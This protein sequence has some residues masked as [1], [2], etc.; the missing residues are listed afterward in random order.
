MTLNAKISITFAKDQK[1]TANVLFLVAVL[2]LLL[3]GIYGWFYWG[4]LKPG[5][6]QGWVFVFSAPIYLTL[7]LVVRWIKHY[8]LLIGFG[9]Y[10]YLAFTVHPVPYALSG[11]W[12]DGLS[13]KLPVLTFLLWGWLAGV[14]QR[15]SKRQWETVLIAILIVL[16]GYGVQFAIYAIIGLHDWVSSVEASLRGTA[17]S[18]AKGT[19][20]AEIVD[21]FCKAN[22]KFI[23]M[24]IVDG[25]ILGV[26]GLAL[27]LMLIKLMSR[28]IKHKSQSNN[29]NTF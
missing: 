16:C 26:C 20:M 10:V 28:V 19:R 17:S 7:G 29:S 1:T 6:W 24:A 27:S 2:Q 25:C 21:I 9:L 5:Y 4:S 3:G 15:Q 22:S 8:S 12:Q 23:R 18:L 11:A 14:D 13:L